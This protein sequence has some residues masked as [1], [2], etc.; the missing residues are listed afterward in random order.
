MMMMWAKL[1]MSSKTPNARVCQE[2]LGLSTGI[3]AWIETLGTLMSVC[4]SAY[5]SHSCLDIYHM[6]QFYSVTQ[7]RKNNPSE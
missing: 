1:Q 3:N 6:G 2:T 5:P 4:L 7:A